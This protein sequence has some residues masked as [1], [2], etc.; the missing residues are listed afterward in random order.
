MKNVGL[1]SF[2]STGVRASTPVALT[3]ARRSRATSCPVCLALGGLD[4]LEG[5]PAPGSLPVFLL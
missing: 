1:Q 5:L 2:I 4:N 3:P